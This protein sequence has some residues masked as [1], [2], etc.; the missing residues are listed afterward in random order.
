MSR[1]TKIYAARQH[2]SSGRAVAV[3]LTRKTPDVSLS[4]YGNNYDFDYNENN[5][6]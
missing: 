3:V 5:G 6:E 2:A 1:L 4:G